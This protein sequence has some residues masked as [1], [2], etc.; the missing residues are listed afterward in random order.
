MDIDEEVEM[1][2]RIETS[3]HNTLKENET[4][5]FC[6]DERFNRKARWISGSASRLA[7]R[8]ESNLVSDK[9]ISEHYIGRKPR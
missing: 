8:Q 6:H 4:P 7:Q 3:K 5:V 2:L 1:A 9:T